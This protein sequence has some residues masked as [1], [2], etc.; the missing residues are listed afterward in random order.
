MHTCTHTFT[1]TRVTAPLKPLTPYGHLPVI[2]YKG[3][4]YAESMAIGRMAGKIS[5]VYPTDP[6]EACVVDSVS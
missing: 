5:G 3:Q 4:I 2:V 6:A 1:C